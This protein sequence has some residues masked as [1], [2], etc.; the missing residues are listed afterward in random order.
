M[1]RLSQSNNPSFSLQRCSRR[2]SAFIS[3]PPLF[4][5]TVVLGKTSTGRLCV[6]RTSYLFFTWKYLFNLPNPIL[7][8]Y[9]QFYAGYRVHSNPRYMPSPTIRG[10][11]FMSSVRPSGRLFLSAVHNSIGYSTPILRDAV[12]LRVLDGFQW[13]LPQIF[14]MW[15]GIVGKVF[16]V[17]GQRSKS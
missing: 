16:K 6:W 17:R 11:G 1:A 10:G 15:L 12:S 3:K 7:E 9:R 13:N 8:I 14:I 5:N 2:H 4:T